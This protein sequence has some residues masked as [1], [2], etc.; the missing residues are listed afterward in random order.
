MTPDQLRT[1]V[2]RGAREWLTPYVDDPA[3]L[4]LGARAF[5][6][7]TSCRI[8]Y[9]LDTGEIAPKPVAG[10]WARHRLDRGWTNLIESALAWRKQDS[11]DRAIPLS[12]TIAFI[13]FV[14]GVVEG[15]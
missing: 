7:L 15:A 9:T 4:H 8:L 3:S 12:E 6:V 5:V 11:D 2:V 1:V 13:H 14:Q 10:A